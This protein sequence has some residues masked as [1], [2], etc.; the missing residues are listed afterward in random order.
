MRHCVD[1]TTDGHNPTPS[2]AGGWAGWAR[3]HTAG[4]WPARSARGLRGAHLQPPASPPP[5][6]EG[7][8]KNAA[9]PRA[10]TGGT[11]LPPAGAPPDVGIRAL[12]FLVA[13]WWDIIRV[14]S[15]VGGGGGR[16]GCIWRRGLDASDGVLG[17]PPFGL[18]R[19]VRRRRRWWWGVGGV[20]ARRAVLGKCVISSVGVCGGGLLPRHVG[21]IFPAETP[22]SGGSGLVSQWAFLILCRRHVFAKFPFWVDVV[23]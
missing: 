19:T 10:A 23:R 18:A 4:L 21:A 20:V 2:P 6:C 22:E 1:V 5:N 16:G 9:A 3:L 11:N 14:T 7:G 13:G 15:V 12:C 17:A 8:E